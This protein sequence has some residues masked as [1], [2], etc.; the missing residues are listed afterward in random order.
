[1]QNMRTP[2]A[3]DYLNI[4]EST[5]EKMRMTGR[6]PAFVKDGRLVIYRKQ[7]LD[8][9]LEARVRQS[10]TDQPTELNGA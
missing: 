3:S 4:P 2:G 5:L 1:M 8:E 7:D 9:W 6:G 10:T